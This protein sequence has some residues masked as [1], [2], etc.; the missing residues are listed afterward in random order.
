MQILCTQETGFVF[1]RWQGTRLSDQGTKPKQ[2]SEYADLWSAYWL[3]V[4]LKSSFTCLF[5]LRGAGILIQGLGYA[6]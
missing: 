3:L 1:W 4:D 6:K 5:H 2:V